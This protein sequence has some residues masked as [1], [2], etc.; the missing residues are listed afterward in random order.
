M[1]KYRVGL[2]VGST[3][4]KTVILDNEGG[5]LFAG[6][7]RHNADIKS[8]LER[9]MENISEQAG[10]SQVSVTVTGSVGMGLA[11]RFM[12]PFIQEVVATV[13]YVK[14]TH[15]GISTIIDIGGEDA[16][17]VYLEPNGNAD[18]RMNGN[19]AGG[20]GAFIDQMA[21]LLGVEVGE[22]DSLARQ[23]ERIYPIA[24]RC[25]VF[26]KTD[27]QNLMSK[28]VAKADIA[29]SIFHAVAVQTVV[30]LSRGCAVVPKILMCGGPLTFIP[31][32]RK[33]FTDYLEIPAEDFVVPENANV[34]AAWGAALS[35]DAESAM[36]V[37]ELRH[38]I[39]SSQGAVERKTNRL[40]PVFSSK[41]EYNSWRTEKSSNKIRRSDIGDVNGDV[42]LGI[43]SGSTTTK[44]VLT[45]ESDNIVYSYYAPNGGDPIS[46]VR[47]GL[48]AIIENCRK[49]GKELKIKGGCSTGYGEDLIKAAFG[50][51]DGIIETIAHYASAKKLNP[52]VSFILD[53]GG[54][55]MKAIFVE[56]GVLSRMEIN[57][58]CS[59]GCGSFLE[60]FANSLNYTVG[61]FAQAACLAEEPCDLGTRCTVFMNSKVKQVLRE[62]ATVGDIAA[63]LSYSVVKN[64]LYKVLKLKKNDELG[65]GIVVQGG[66]MRNDSVVRALELLTEASV[67]RSDIPELMGAY[68][69]AL[70]AKSQSA[71]NEA[72]TV[73]SMLETA[74]YITKQVNCRGCENVCYVNKYSFANGN[75]YYSGN[76]CEKVFHNGGSAVDKGRNI[77][78]EKNRLLFDRNGME[79]DSALTIG[80]PRCLNMYENYP[81]WHTLFNECGIRTVLS[82]P[83]TFTS[84]ESG[85][86]TVMS[87]NICF[88]AKLVHSHIYDLEKKEVDRIFLPYVVF[89]KPEG[90]KSANSYNCPIVSGYSEV[91]K[92]AVEPSAP[93]DSPVITFKD[94]KLLSK[95]CTAYLIGLGINRKVASTAVEKALAEQKRYEN[96]LRRINIEAYE[97]SK[98]S[99]RLTILLAGRPYHTDPLIQ[100]KLSN[101]ISDMGATVITEDIARNDNT[102]SEHEAHFVSQWAY[103]NRIMNAARWTAEQGPDVQ[104]VQMTSFG[105]GPDAFL[106]DEVKD[107]LK[108]NGKALT[109]LKV[110]DVN[111]IGS[112]KLR[113]RSVLE[114]LKLSG[115]VSKSPE[116]LVTTKVFTKE[117]RRRTILAP[118]FT[119]YISPLIP[120]VLR[121]AG[122]KVEVLPES[123]TASADYGLMYANNEVCY[124][125][126]LIVGDIIK[127]L[128]SGKYDL[129]E[130]AVIITQTGGQCRASNYIALIK[131]GLAEAG[132]TEVPV[133]SLAMGSG[134]VNEQSGFTI[135]WPKV[136]PITL[137]AIL[138]GDC[139]SKFYHASVVREKN[140]GDA[141]K[142]REHY[143]QAAKT[144]IS[145]NS[146]SALYKLME[147]AANSFNDVTDDAKADLPKV[148][149]VG[150]IFLKFNSFAHKRVSQW[151]ITN[152]IEVAP[153]V[154]TDFFTQTF[155]NRRVKKETGIEKSSF[156]SWIESAAYS[157]I[158]KK[159]NEVNRIGSCFKYFTP[160][161]DIFATAE[162]GREIVTLSAQFGEGWLL[163]AEIVSFAKHG[164]NN[165]ISLQPFGCI[166]NHIIS[167]GVEK[168]IKTLY[169]DMNLLS[170]DFDGGVS[171]VNITNR[172]LL[173]TNNLK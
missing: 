14:Q 5:L 143:L 123:D 74:E 69:C 8:T 73:E 63:G 107:I 24:S 92:S 23:S 56:N 127:A 89:E 112:I 169:P 128:D 117:D 76:K 110:D 87:D 53:I 157:L 43:D 115:G 144:C 55:D 64:C 70:Y 167:K 6:Y 1:K 10:D 125:A 33:A 120:D 46:T 88:P 50:L 148:G 62:G 41:E 111:N 100:H 163:P 137:A 68:G 116:P 150:E 32:L 80:I 42:Y 126:T 93:V 94:K 165:V 72:Y 140:P 83:S 162:N 130:T 81:F 136:I 103:V 97:Q 118:F 173:M 172:L 119:D 40:Q 142:L 67:T 86:H 154:L 104:F 66:T 160:F 51:N 149:I 30:T 27:V 52:E 98:S 84:Y 71:G 108:R 141:L 164:V 153:P 60:T 47:K 145:M 139:L 135:N 113:V 13:E 39:N 44:I 26:S 61:D 95:G 3:T 102:G 158:R 2:D 12:L 21:V 36:S 109:M 168:K 19:C 15:P 54:Q 25:G 38:L 166:A 96:E 75:V 99:G 11:E 159:I 106:L 16:K 34:I 170:L 85:V 79:T 132:F 122:Y 58:A 114:S 90:R 77:S 29:A 35:A 18:L 138:F 101:M 129:S 152:G 28:N 133:L 124:P 65:D 45:D 57:E 134:L 91:I 171:D 82:A 105:C 37:E 48:E 59:S 17:I 121:L 20:T 131:R 78:E 9:I 155:V 156:P 161:E 4:A 146:P 147:Q 22:M 151:L 31:S 49:A 7:V